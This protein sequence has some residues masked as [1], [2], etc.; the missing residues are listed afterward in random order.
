MPSVDLFTVTALIGLD[1]ETDGLNPLK[2]SLRAVGLVA[3]EQN[4]MLL[5][6]E[7]EIVVRPSESRTPDSKTLEWWS[8]EA[9]NEWERLQHAEAE[10]LRYALLL[11]E[12][13][14]RV[15]FALYPQSAILALHPTF[16]VGWL[17]T[18]SQRV[19]EREIIPHR[20]V[21]WDLAVLRAMRPDIPREIPQCP[22]NALSDARAQTIEGWNIIKALRQQLKDPAA[23]SAATSPTLP[24]HLVPPVLLE[25]VAR[26]FEQGAQKYGANQ[27][28]AGLQDPAWLANRANHALA[29]LLNYMHG[30]KQDGDSP[31]DNLAAAGWGI[32]TLLEAERLKARGV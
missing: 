13:Y 30:V 3:Y 16:D 26:R 31:S 18:L 15:L 1:I 20:M 28:R 11:V 22:H 19:L 5:I 23:P 29:H 7:R 6:S 25:A 24:Y 32:A 14:L 12:M 10:P 27:W 4:E 9:P 8:R 2:Q 21:V 17:N